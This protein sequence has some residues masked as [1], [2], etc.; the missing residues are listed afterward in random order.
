M[1]SCNVCGE[2][3][4]E[5]YG[6]EFFY[7]IGWT[8]TSEWYWEQIYKVKHPN[9]HNDDPTGAALEKLVLEKAGW[10]QGGYLCDTC[11]AKMKSQTSYSGG[12]IPYNAIC[13]A[14]GRVWEKLYGKWPASL[15]KSIK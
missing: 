13:D 14:A 9:L 7:K 5:E 3:Y 12:D 11:F 2:S 15:K 1:A 6:I 4:Y 8:R 10:K